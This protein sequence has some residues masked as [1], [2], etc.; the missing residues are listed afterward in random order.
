MP[1]NNLALLFGSPLKQHWTIRVE[2]VVRLLSS[3]SVDIVVVVFPGVASWEGVLSHST[4]PEKNEGPLVLHRKTTASILIIRLLQL[5]ER[6][7][8][9]SF[10]LYDQFFSCNLSMSRKKN[11]G[12]VH[13]TQGCAPRQNVASCCQ[14][15]SWFRCNMK[16]VRE[17]CRL[18]WAP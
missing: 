13:V 14:H 5:T 2:L 11:G 17:R 18:I 7:F 4:I 6:T 10:R 9:I 3:S 8:Y 16:T 12:K 1:N 15:N